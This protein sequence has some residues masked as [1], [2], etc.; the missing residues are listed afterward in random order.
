MTEKIQQNRLEMQLAA[1]CAPLLTGIKISNLFIVDIQEKEEVIKLFEKTAI[2]YAVIYESEAKLTFLLYLEEKLLDYM[3]QK[4]V[5][6][7]M[8]ILGHSD[9]RLASILV[10][11]KK[12]YT[13]YMERR[14][15]FPHELGLLLGYPAEDVAGFIQNNGKN[16]LYTGYWKV[17][18]DV[19]RALNLFEQYN[20]A[21]KAVTQMVASG[22]SIHSII[23]SYMISRNL[24]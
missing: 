18:G 3:N 15:Q 21:K 2:S 12:R 23:N 7:L 16:F 14:E 19:K 8:R 5:R 22:T 24:E 17:Y 4:P 6:D 11:V 1:Q 9:S 20:K 13:A 10:E